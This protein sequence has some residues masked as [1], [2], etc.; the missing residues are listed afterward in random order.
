M[1]PEHFP[2]D[3]IQMKVLLSQTTAEYTKELKFTLK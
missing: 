2:M 1:Q 3:Y